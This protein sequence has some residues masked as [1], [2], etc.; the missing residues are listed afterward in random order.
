MVMLQGINVYT[1]KEGSGN[2]LMKRLRKKLTKDE[3]E[4]FES[5]SS[6][7]HKTKLQRKQ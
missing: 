1:V 7:I 3:Y 6:E 2:S 4:L 5:Y